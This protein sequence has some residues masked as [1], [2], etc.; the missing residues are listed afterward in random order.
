MG[1][2]DKA[3]DFNSGQSQDLETAKVQTP[4]ANPSAPRQSTAMVATDD[5]INAMFFDHIKYNQAWRVAQMFACTALVPKHFQKKP[6]DVFIA[7]NLANR[8]GVD[9][10]M[11]MQNLYVVHGTPGYYAKFVIAMVNEKG[12]FTGPIQW[13]MSGKGNDRECVA[14]ATHRKTGEKCKAKVTWDMVVKE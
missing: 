1:L 7:L 3:A 5:G 6:E 2:A 12:P 4:Q 10:L 8:L 9:P 14:Y 11:L 13:K